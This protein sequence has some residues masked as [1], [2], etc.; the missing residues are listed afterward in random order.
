MKQF[1]V[2]DLG[3]QIK[4]EMEGYKAAN[5]FRWAI[6]KDGKLYKRGANVFKIATI[7]E[8]ALAMKKKDELIDWLLEKDKIKS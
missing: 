1:Q 7:P 5:G 2:Q 8:L 4:A 6:Y 3:Y